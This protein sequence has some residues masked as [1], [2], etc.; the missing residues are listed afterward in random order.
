MVLNN[1]N[2]NNSILFEVLP[3]VFTVSSYFPDNP[4]IC[5]LQKLALCMIHDF[6]LLIS[7][8]PNRFLEFL[9]IKKCL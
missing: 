9:D 8:I 5:I 1:T 7:R 4:R 3:S 2:K 6:E